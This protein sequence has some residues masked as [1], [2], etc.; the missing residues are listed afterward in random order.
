MKEKLKVFKIGGNVIDNE[1]EL[2]LFLEDFAAVSGHKILV[3]GGGKIATQMASRMGVATQMVEGRRVT[4]QEMLD[5]VLMVYGGL[6]NKKIVAKLQALGCDALGLTGADMNCMVASKRPVQTID[7]GFAGDMQYVN[8][9]VFYRLL[10][11]NITPILAP[12]THD[13]KGQLLN[14]NAD[15]IAAAT[16]V[17]LTDN[18][19]VSLFFCFEKAGVLTDIQ[20]ESSLIE[21]LNFNTYLELKEEG[22]IADGMVP[23][24]DNA[25]QTM[26][27]GVDQ[28]CIMHHSQVKNIEKQEFKATTLN[29]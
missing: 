19:F 16:A 4:T 23:K 14:T 5:V 26:Q 9:N 20:R 24:L 18:F 22:I 15:T 25:F 1:Q 10:Q 28:V 8:S 29:L 11:Q 27:Q 6:V 7:Y 12:L 3:H 17:A 13:Q 2:S 21:L